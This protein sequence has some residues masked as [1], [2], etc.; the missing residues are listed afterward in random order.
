MVRRVSIVALL[1]ALIAVALPAAAQTT[2]GVMFM[3]KKFRDAEV[4]GGEPRP[5]QSA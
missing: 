5:R 4:K 1:F 2:N 3:A